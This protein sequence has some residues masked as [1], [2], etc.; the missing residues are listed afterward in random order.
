MV[1]SKRPSNPPAIVN[2]AI[3]ERPWHL[4]CWRM[5]QH[6]LPLSEMS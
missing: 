4:L 3:T 1:V 5:S 6:N 2:M